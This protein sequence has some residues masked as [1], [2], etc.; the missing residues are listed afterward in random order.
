KIFDPFFTTSKSGTGLGLSVSYDIVNKHNG[1]IL[2]EEG[3][4]NKG[5]KFTVQLPIK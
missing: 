3:D 4:D 5:T 1:R 2:V